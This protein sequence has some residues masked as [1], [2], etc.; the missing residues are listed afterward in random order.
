MCTPSPADISK[1]AKAISPDVRALYDLNRA[2]WPEV[3][4]DLKHHG[5]R[6]VVAQT[7]RAALEVVPSQRSQP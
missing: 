6:V 2:K 7:A 3:V 1:A 5:I 4:A